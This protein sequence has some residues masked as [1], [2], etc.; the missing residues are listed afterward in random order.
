MMK[1]YVLIT[2]G[3]NEGNLIHYPVESVLSQSYL[4]A[5]WVIVS[6]GSTDDTDDIVRKY[7]EKNS[8]IRY[9]RLEKDSRN[10]GFESKVVALRH[11]YNCL[12]GKNYDYIGVLDA[13][14]S[15]CDR[16]FENIL[17]EFIKNGKLGI[18]GGYIYEPDRN[19]VF[20]PRSHNRERSV[21]GA[22]QM[23]RRECYEKIGGL[24][25]IIYGGEDT[26]AEILA[27]TFGWEVRSFPEYN[28]FHHKPGYLKRGLWKERIREGKL[29]YVLGNFTIYEIMKF[30]R[31]MHEYPFIIGSFARLSGYFLAS[32]MREDKIPPPHILRNIR[33]EQWHIL[34]NLFHNHG[35]T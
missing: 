14:I 27:R 19:G 25:P 26:Y 17:E 32:M 28:V 24:K 31:R 7:A 11:A 5:R 20:S 34:L 2:A 10:K 23:F 18:A 13:D 33:S 35:A 30:F 15:F 3:H 6:D 29:D 16:Y 9:C 21:S 4:P 12:K 22:V 1:S 8:F